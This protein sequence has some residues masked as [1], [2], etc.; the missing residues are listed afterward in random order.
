MSGGYFA[1]M[2]IPLMAGRTFAESDSADAPGVVI[3]SQALARRYWSKQNPVGKHL[4]FDAKNPWT[5]VVGLVADVRGLLG[6]S[7]PPPPA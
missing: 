3:V 4:R 6:L 7:K 1:A 2:G 5:T